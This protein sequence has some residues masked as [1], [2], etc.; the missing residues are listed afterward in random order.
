MAPTAPRP[1]SAGRDLPALYVSPWRLLRQDLVAV[2]ASLRLKLWE[3]GR[4]NASGEL[5]RPGFWPNRLAAW[6]WP[7]LLTLGLTLLLALAGMVRHGMASP[8]DLAPNGFRREVAGSPAETSGP[9]GALAN[10][11]W[12]SGASAMDPSASPPPAPRAQPYPTSLGEQPASPLLLAEPA[13]LA[14]PAVPVDPPTASSGPF[15]PPHSAELPP[16]SG[17]VAMPGAASGVGPEIGASPVD[18]NSAEPHQDS[19]PPPASAG[20]ADGLGEAEAQ[21]KALLG[22][23]GEATPEA[24][25]QA[26]ELGDDPTA[27][28]LRMAAAFAGGASELRQIWANRWL[29][30]VRQQGYSQLTLED[31]A[32]RTLGRQAR[33]GSGMILLQPYSAPP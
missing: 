31:G 4:R 23:L 17:A 10:A 30:L 14:G 25:P 26:A 3:M 28:R 16:A 21:T 5:P 18:L 11:G 27:V 12:S 22:L 8:P 1:E 29:E 13:T 32:G 7:L 20:E 24:P 2:L 9:M 15:S 19:L 6:F 33:A